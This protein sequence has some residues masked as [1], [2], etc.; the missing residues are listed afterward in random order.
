MLNHGASYLQGGGPSQ[1]SYRSNTVMKFDG[2]DDYVD[3]DA[4]RVGDSFTFSLWVKPDS[5]PSSF[6]TLFGKHDK[7]VVMR[8]YSG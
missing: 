4:F 7:M 5:W 6:N 2:V 3:T 8:F 1:L